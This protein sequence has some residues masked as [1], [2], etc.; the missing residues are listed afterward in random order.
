MVNK[1]ALSFFLTAEK[2]VKNATEVLG[3]HYHATYLPYY[4][5]KYH[6]YAVFYHLDYARKIVGSAIRLVTS[7]LFLIEAVFYKPK[8]S[9]PA[10]CLG[11]LIEVAAALVNVINM[12]V[13]I[14]ALITRSLATLLNGGYANND[15]QK[16]HGK[17]IGGENEETARN[18]ADVLNTVHNS[19]TIG[20]LDINIFKLTSVMSM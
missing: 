5:G 3:Y 4:S 15:S 18:L 6:F 19:E 1:H 9:I 10:V 14:A 8:K 20:T 7:P 12:L 11:V 16:L 17:E 13:S 2:S